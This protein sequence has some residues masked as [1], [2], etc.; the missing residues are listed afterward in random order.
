MQENGCKNVKQKT[1]IIYLVVKAKWLEVVVI[2]LMCCSV[3]CPTTNQ[4]T[5][6]PISFVFQSE[7]VLTMDSAS[8]YCSLKELGDSEAITNT[9]VE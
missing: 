9:F 3:D 8:I 4:L 1:I 6:Y 2:S 7:M 5:A